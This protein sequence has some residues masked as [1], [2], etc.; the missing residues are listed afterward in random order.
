[1]ELVHP[2]RLSAPR[3]LIS[4]HDVSPLTL[5]ECRRAIA[6]L[7]GLDVQP[8]QLSCL[9]IPQHEGERAIDQDRDTLRFL[10]ELADAGATLVMHGLTHRMPGRARTPAGWFRGHLFAR[11]QGE[12]FRCDAADAER[13]LDQGRAIFRRAGLESALRGFVPPAW[14]LSPAAL[15]VV[16][17]A[18]FEFYELFGGIQHRGRRLV[19]RVIGWGS[20]SG[21]EARA[22]A[23]YADLQSRLL[24]PADTRVAVHPADMRRPSQRRAITR[25]LK[26]VLARALPVSYDAYLAAV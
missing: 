6:L 11:G 14:L 15:D 2:E 4:L 8:A 22:T 1:M 17:G 16:R 5:G 23:L 19:P 24:T 26:R 7:S 10:G 12:F 20:L 21:I 13:R 9:V 25:V 18:G 3:A